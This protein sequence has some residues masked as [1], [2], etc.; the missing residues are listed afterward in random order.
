MNIG[1]SNILEGTIV[2]VHEGAV[3]GTVGIEL[4]SG[5]VVSSSITMDSIEKLGLELGM[6]A[7]ACIKATDVIVCTD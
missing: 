4:P 1:A 7:Y 3:N 2:F 5:Q 6:K